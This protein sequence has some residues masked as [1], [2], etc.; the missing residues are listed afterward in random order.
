M[1]KLLAAMIG[2]LLLAGC[3]S[4]AAT[5]NQS[6][7]SVPPAT[8]TPP[9]PAATP[10]EEPTEEPKEPAAESKY[11]VTIE[12]SRVTKTYNGKPALIVNFT[13]TNN[14]DE[15]A[16]FMFATR[17]QAFQDGIELDTAIIMDDKKYDS[18]SAMKDIKPGKSL[19]VQSAFE[20]QDKKTDVEIEV[21]EFISF[22]DSVLAAAVL[23]LKK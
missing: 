5:P 18:G 2:L 14:S 23:K 10:T 11:A 21:T 22:D 16:N 7:P 1:K 20:L 9:S 19:K 4:S 8:S 12:D 13:F 6:Q 3:G 15:A 17:V